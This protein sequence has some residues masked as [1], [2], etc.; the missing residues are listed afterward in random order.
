[1]KVGGTRQPFLG[2]R[3]GC[4]WDG[5]CIRIDGR[6]G[7]EKLCFVLVKCQQVVQG[8]VV[9]GNPRYWKYSTNTYQRWKGVKIEES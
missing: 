2:K 1:M 4:S 5:L 3:V 7:N 9:G 6:T 8:K